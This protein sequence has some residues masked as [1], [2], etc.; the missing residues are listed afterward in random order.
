M[1]H[2]HKRPHWAE[3]FRYD[4][5]SLNEPR[6]VLITD[7]CGKRSALPRLGYV[8]LP[9]RGLKRKWVSDTAR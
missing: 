9:T 3:T 5:A 6:V 1:N 4:L 2:Y 8:V 7:L